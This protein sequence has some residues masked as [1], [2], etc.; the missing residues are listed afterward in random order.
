MLC[1]AVPCVP[2]EGPRCAPTWPFLPTGMV[3]EGQPQRLTQPITVLPMRTV[4]S[5]SWRA[6][7]P[8]M[9]HHTKRTVVIVG[10]C[11]WYQIHL[12][13][14]A[15]MLRPELAG[16]GGAEVLWCQPFVGD[17][18][19][20]VSPCSAQCPVP[21]AVQC[22]AVQCSECSAVPCSAVQ[23]SESSAVQCSAVQCSAVQ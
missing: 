8:D 14:G 2:T 4:A 17:A 3:T 5:V 10:C 16:L 12:P 15:P 18:A 1:C 11:C 21:S 19:K 20:G 23:C 13:R 6:T 7:A 22:S 9:N